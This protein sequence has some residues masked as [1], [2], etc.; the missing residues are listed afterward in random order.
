MYMNQKFGPDDA[1]IHKRNI[2]GR[3]RHMPSDWAT[4]GLVR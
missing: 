4:L 3:A 1:Y 2:S